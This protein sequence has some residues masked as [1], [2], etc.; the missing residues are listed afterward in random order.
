M[1]A[2]TRHAILTSAILLT[3]CSQG[4]TDA[5]KTEDAVTHSNWNFSEV[6]QNS[7]QDGDASTCILTDMNGRAFAI[8][9]SFYTLDAKP[10]NNFP[11]IRLIKTLGN[12][13]P[14][15]MSEDDEKTVWEFDQGTKIET[16][17]MHDYADGQNTF[18]AAFADSQIILTALADAK[19]VVITNDGLGEMEYDVAGFGE[20]YTNMA[21]ACDFN[22][23][24]V[25]TP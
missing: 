23:I 4:G 22:T 19:S 25:L 8:E 2:I 24:G 7:D 10:P 1:F 21:S 20:A 6:S 11:T 17:M 16:R 18:T 15:A 3:A 5:A 14:M 12:A 9:V 13:G